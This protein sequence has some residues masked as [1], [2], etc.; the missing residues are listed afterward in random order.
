MSLKAISI[1]GIF[2]TFGHQFGTQI[3]QFIVQIILARVLL[4][5]E[6]GLIGVLAVFMAL[7][8]SLVDSGMSS[9]LIRS[10][11]LDDRD[12]SSV[13]V[14]NITVS[15][16]V[17]LILF[18]ASPIIS[19]FFNQPILSDIVK[20]YCLSFII[21]AISSIQ[22]VRL[23]I[24]MDFKTQTKLRLPALAISSIL[25]LVLAYRGY[26]VWSLVYMQLA[27]VT[28]ESILIWFQVDWRPSFILDWNRLKHHF[29]FGYKLTL[30]GIIDI[31]YSNIYHIIIGKYFSAAQLGFYTRAQSMR[32]LPV[33]NISSALNQVT[34]PLFSSI[35]NDDVR[36]KRL[37]K[38]LM[39]QVLYWIAPILV[40]AGVLGEPLF[41]FLMTE[42][43]LPAVPYFQILCLGGIMYPLHAYNL[44]ILNVKGRSDLFLKLEIVKKALI[45]IGLLIA[46]P[47]GIYGLLWMQFV[48]TIS[49]FLINT[50]FSGK[51]I[52]YSMLEQIK[53]I[54]PILGLTAIIG[55]LVFLVDMQLPSSSNFDFIR[56]VFGTVLGLGGYISISFVTRFKPFVDFREFILNR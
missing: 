23:T 44:N 19:I 16:F 1:Q 34:Y 6:F 46:I 11:D 12:F 26:G 41:R 53:D 51:M 37:Y 36:L 20:V 30:S 54:L 25:G 40:I 21:R 50:S 13:F 31:V 22:Y 17:Y 10:Q 45:S 48:L 39:Q 3:I 28:F 38:R 35:H 29:N 32:Q 4:P 47:F 56:L 8:N 24:L 55:V 9:S 7:G 42:K 15:V 43:W 27:N 33:S 2:W 52:N 5:E 18:F 49:A 14:I